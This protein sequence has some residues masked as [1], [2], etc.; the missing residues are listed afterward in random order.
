MN[1]YDVLGVDKDASEGEIK[2]SYRKKASKLHPDK[3][4]NKEGFQKLQH[5]YEVLSDRSRRKKYDETGTSQKEDKRH[6]ILVALLSIMRQVIEGTPNPEHHDLVDLVRKHV[7]NAQGSVSLEENKVRAHRAKYE[8]LRRKFQNKKTGENIFNGMVESI[9][10]DDTL[11][12]EKFADRKSE[13]VL[14][15]E[16]LSDYS[17][18]REMMS[19]VSSGMVFY[20]SP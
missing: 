5:A 15:L 3:G 16:L 2:N 19:N 11:S 4:G 9:I 1:L 8:K 18:Q 13:L 10:R 6:E 14:M 12:L 17:F 7:I 20:T